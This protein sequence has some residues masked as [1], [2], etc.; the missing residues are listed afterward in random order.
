[1]Y[2]SFDYCFCV[3]VHVIVCQGLGPDQW[4]AGPA[5]RSH[6][7]E[8]GDSR[9]GT[10]QRSV[11]KLHSCLLGTR[12]LSLHFSL[13]SPQLFTRFPWLLWPKMLGFCG[14][15]LL[16]I[17]HNLHINSTNLWKIYSQ[18]GKKMLF[19]FLGFTC[20]GRQIQQT[21]TFYQHGPTTSLCVFWDFGLKTEKQFI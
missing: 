3:S 15:F 10:V 13:I 17:A 20:I 11:H 7:G 18:G 21:K 6:K 19:S 5:G 4:P 2:W 9:K 8:A 16:K 14:S 12:L 1:M